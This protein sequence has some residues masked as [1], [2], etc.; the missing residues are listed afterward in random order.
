M[1]ARYLACSPVPVVRTVVIFLAALVVAVTL[2]AFI[3]EPYWWARIW[4]YPRLQ[5]AAVGLIALV[6]YGLLVARRAKKRK[7][8]VW[9]GFALLT[10]CVV[11][12]AARMLPYTPLWPVEAVAVAGEPE[13]TLRVV[14]TNVT[15]TNR[16]AARW[17]RE[18]LGAEPDVVAAVETDAWWVEAMRGRLGAYPHR[19]EVPQSNTYGIALYSRFPLEDAEVL[20]LVEPTVPSVFARVV[21]PSG[22]RVQLAVLHPRPPRPDIAQG[23]EFRDAELVLAAHVLNGLQ[24]PALAV[25]DLNTV[26][27]SRQAREFLA[28][29][30]LLDPRIGRSLYPTFPAAYPFLR[31]PLDHAFYSEGLALVSFRR[32]SKVGSDHLPVL[33]ELAVAPTAARRQEAPD[34]APA[35]RR[36]AREALEEA[37]DQLREETPAETRERNREDR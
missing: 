17:A 8:L 3:R 28:L 18:V 20:R 16:D 12:Q 19:V 14:V 5:I 2:L 6:L 9:G 36:S 7:K 37:R 33:I 26:A 34:A 22:E 32:L 25:G 10:A 1:S 23:A 11:Y 15:M 27:W 29:A 21:L 35:D 13:R 4:E 30:Q 31:Y 24:R